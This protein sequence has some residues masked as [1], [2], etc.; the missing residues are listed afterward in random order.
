MTKE[1]AIKILKALPESIISIVLPFDIEFDYKQALEM[2]I[3]ALEQEQEPKIS[4]EVYKQVTK[5]RD[6]AIEQLH[7]L[8]YEFG[9]KIPTTQERQAESDKFDAAFQDGYNNGY[10]QARFDYAQEPTINKNDLTEQCIACKYDE[11][12][13]ENGEH[14]KKCLA[15]DNQFELDKEFVQPTT[16][17][18]LG[19]DCISRQEVL[20]I[21]KASK[22]NWIDNSILFKRV[23]ELPSITPQEPRKGHWIGNYQVDFGEWQEYDVKLSD[24][25]VTD[26]CHCS[27]CGEELLSGDRG[28]FCPYCGADMRAE[29]EE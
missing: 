10:A 26:N 21:A 6:I 5:E 22:S 7:E 23:N 13:D 17:N 2:A 27:E 9:E 8:G 15:G 19:V 11:T 4:L 3:K 18:D 25:F 29:V 16:K 12:E 20:N 28:M 14:C 1:E 24:G